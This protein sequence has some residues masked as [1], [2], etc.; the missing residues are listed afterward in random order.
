MLGDKMS[1]IECDKCH[2]KMQVKDLV[3]KTV[4]GEFNA[5][6]GDRYGFCPH[7]DCGSFDGGDTYMA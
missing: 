4:R 1:E 3:I 7:C 6:C 5:L 2:A